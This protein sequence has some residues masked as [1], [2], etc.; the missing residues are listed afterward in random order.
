MPIKVPGKRTRHGSKAP[1]KRKAVAVLQLTAMVDMFTVLV[2]FLLQNYATTDQILPLPDR[3][4][5]PSARSVKEL[6]PSNVVVLSDEEVAL[7]SEKVIDADIVRS[8][9]AW[10][11]EPLKNQVE[12]LIEKGEKEKAR[13]DRRLKT[14][15]KTYKEDLGT[16]E[17]EVDEFRKITIQADKNIHFLTVKKIMY[18]V[19]E[20]GVY[21]INFAVLKDEE[22]TQ[23]ASL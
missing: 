12:K 4:D 3:V 17:D 22:Q 15:V 7:N 19:T 14:A 2:V 1:T 6:K 21:E 9:E 11:I 18:T 5:L 16:S 10:L 20:A 8:S 23:A 13:L